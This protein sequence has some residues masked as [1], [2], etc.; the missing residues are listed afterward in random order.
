VQ[1][2]DEQ[3][4]EVVY[5]LRIAGTTFRPKVFRAG[6]YTLRLGEGTQRQVLQGV[7]STAEGE[8]RRIT[9]RLGK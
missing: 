8:R 1:V 3:N 5:T 4:D 6:T 9:V 7:P 2:V